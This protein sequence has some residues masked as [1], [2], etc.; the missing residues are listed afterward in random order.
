MSI[1]RNLRDFM[2]ADSLHN[3]M[4]TEDDGGDAE[5]YLMLRLRLTEGVKA[6][7]LRQRHPE[8]SWDLLCQKAKRYEKTGLIRLDPDP[9]TGFVALTPEGFLVSNALIARLCD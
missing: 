4:T 7:E 5:E 6:S 9:R 1:P 8:M 3:I 2:A